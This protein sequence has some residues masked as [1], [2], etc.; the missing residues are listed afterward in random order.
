M[1]RTWSGVAAGEGAEPIVARIASSS[2]PAS[3]STLRTSFMSAS[4]SLD[5]RYERC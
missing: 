5:A 2:K 3:V 4:S 1:R